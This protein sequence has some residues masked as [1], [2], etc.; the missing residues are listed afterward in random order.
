[1]NS[2]YAYIQDGEKIIQY[3]F[4]AEKNVLELS[5]FKN[6]KTNIDNDIVFFKKGD[7]WGVFSLKDDMII[8]YGYSF[9]GLKKDIDS[10]ILKAN[11]YIALKDNQ[12]F[13]LDNKFEALSSPLTKT[14]KTYTDEYIICTDNTIYD[15]TGIEVVGVDRFKDIRTID[16]YIVGITNANIAIV[17]INPQTEAVGFTNLGEYTN[18]DIKFN[19]NMMEFY[20]NDIL[21][22]S[23]ALS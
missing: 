2:E 5:A 13:I 10:G 7:K 17:Y 19:N 11:R 8:N 9:I 18:L 3:S 4:A 6:Y 20:N 23:I 15:F 21:L 22:Q 16:N 12:W 1:M 14:I